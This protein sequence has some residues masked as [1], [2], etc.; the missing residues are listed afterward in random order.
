MLFVCLFPGRKQEIVK[1]TEQLIS[2]ITSGDYEAFTYVGIL[3][4]IQY[5]NNKKDRTIGSTTRGCI[6]YYIR[7][8]FFI[9]KELCLC[10]VEKWLI[11][12]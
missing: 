11:H 9:L 8:R 6:C 7:W 1:L 4:H 10:V 5:N 3:N 2:A 12:S